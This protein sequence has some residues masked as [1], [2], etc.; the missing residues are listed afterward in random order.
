MR[1]LATLGLAVLALITGALVYLDASGTLPPLFK[2][3]VMP[4]MGSLLLMSFFS[5]FIGLVGLKIGRHDR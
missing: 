4:A 1:L 5:I 3:L 2:P